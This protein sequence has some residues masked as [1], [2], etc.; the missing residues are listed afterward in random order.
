MRHRRLLAAALSPVLLLSPAALA[1]VEGQKVAAAAPEKHAA[2]HDIHRWIDDR[3]FGVIIVDIANADIGAVMEQVANSAGRIESGGGMDKEDF[4]RLK[5]EFLDAKVVAEQ[6]LTDIRAAGAK[7]IWILLSPE[8]AFCIPLSDGADAARLK[9]LLRTA[10]LADKDSRIIQRSGV[11]F[12]GSTLRG[13]PR[14]EADPDRSKQLDAAFASVAALNDGKPVAKAALIP[15]DA[16][17][18]VMSAVLPRIAQHANVQIAQDLN[19]KLQWA[20]IALSSLPNPE[21]KAIV[22]TTGTLPAQQVAA[23]ANGL[24]KQASEQAPPGALVEILRELKFIAN[25]DRAELT[26]TSSTTKRITEGLVLPLV[27]AREAARRVK[28][29]STARQYLVA[30]HAYSADNQDK[31]PE[32][33]DDLKPFIGDADLSHPAGKEWVYTKPADK[34]SQIENPATAIVMHEEFKTWPKSGVVTAFADG[35]VEVVE[36]EDRFNELR[37]AK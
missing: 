30:V 10:E 14:A 28:A 12:A 33:L 9:D 7:E 20:G 25:E 4:E 34:L 24:L 35:H 6:W 3:M 21:A 22:Q 26:I 16:H 29:M 2:V 32:T 27:K 37:K 1:Q 19:T 18:L 13:L 5:K 17:R 36:T 8:P 31:F 11:L 23:L 15:T